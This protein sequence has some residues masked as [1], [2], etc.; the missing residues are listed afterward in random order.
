MV[1]SATP[2]VAD[3]TSLAICSPPISAVKAAGS[4]LSSVYNN[5]FLLSTSYASKM[6]LTFEADFNLMADTSVEYNNA[7]TAIEGILFFILL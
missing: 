7:N 2:A 4:I 6:S 5:S 3:L 1:L